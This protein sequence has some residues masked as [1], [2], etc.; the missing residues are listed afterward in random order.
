MRGG[1]LAWWYCV[2]ERGKPS[3]VVLHVC[4]RGG[5]LASCL[6]VLCVWEGEA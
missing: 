4:M 6:V 1:S 5:S 2:Y 3:L